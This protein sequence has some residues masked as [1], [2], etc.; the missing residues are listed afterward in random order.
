MSYLRE[1][2]IILHAASV[3]A[4]AIPIGVLAATG[5]IGLAVLSFVAFVLNFAA[6]SKHIDY[7]SGL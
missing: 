7:L 6:L 3:M 5:H 4:C 2:L 1:V